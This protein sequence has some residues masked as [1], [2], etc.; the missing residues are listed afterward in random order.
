MLM[1]IKETLLGNW[2]V[3]VKINIDLCKCAYL[4]FSASNLF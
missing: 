4:E 3:P 2:S 1:V